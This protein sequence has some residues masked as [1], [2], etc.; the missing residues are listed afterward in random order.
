[1]MITF[2]GLMEKTGNSYG[3]IQ[4]SKVINDT[5]AIAR[6]LGN[7]VLHIKTCCV[8]KVKSHITRYQELQHYKQTRKG[9][10][11]GYSENIKAPITS[12]HNKSSAAIE[13]TIH[14]S[15][16]SIAS[17]NDTNSSE[18]LGFTSA[19]NITSE[20]NSSFFQMVHFFW[21]WWQLSRIN[22]FQR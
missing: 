5:K 1:M 6:V 14:R 19:S 13:S 18:I 20:N 2:W 10:L 8:P 21:Y 22:Y 17:S 4:V 9:V 16:K 12:L 3:V 7:K 11:L 15:S